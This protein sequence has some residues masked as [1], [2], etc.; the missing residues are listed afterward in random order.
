MIKRSGVQIRTR[1]TQWLPPASLSE[2]LKFR[3]LIPYGISI[4]LYII[5]IDES[6]IMLG[7]KDSEEGK[8]LVI[9]S[10]IRHLSNTVEAAFGS[11]PLLSIDNVTL[12]GEAG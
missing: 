11:E 9:Q 8:Q 12:P 7:E 2:W 6:E 5:C 1:S 10:I 4:C 3:G